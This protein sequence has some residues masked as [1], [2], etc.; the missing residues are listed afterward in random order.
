MVRVSHVSLHIELERWPLTTPFRTTAQTIEVFDAI[1]VHLSKDTHV[2]RGE[3]AGIYFQNET[4]SSMREQIE[5]MRGVIEAG[6]SHESL[7]MLL[8]PGGARNALDCALWDLEAKLTKQPVWE[9]LGLP[10]PRRLL[11][12]FTCG[13]DRPE[14][15]A[16]AARAY[17]NARALKLKLTGSAADGDCVRAV[18][19]ARPDVWLGI[20]ANQGFSLAHLESL[21][22]VLTEERV[23]LIEQPFPVGREELLDGLQSPIPIAA[24]ESVRSAADIPSLVGRFSVANIKLDKSGGLTEALSLARALRAAGLDTMVGNMMGTSLAMAPAFLVGQLC[25]LVDLDG[26]AFLRE[27]RA[28]PADYSDG[29]IWCPEG[30]WGHAESDPPGKR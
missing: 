22:G 26:P 5:P 17:R 18:R 13:A 16:A 4:P 19:D 23:S 29:H 24:D 27:D 30:L 20:D 2:G 11:T 8:P 10:Q 28:P 12:T 15:M 25:D 3:A 21:L 7:Q 6:L 1:V 9:K 14:K